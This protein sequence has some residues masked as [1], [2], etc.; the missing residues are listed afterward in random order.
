MKNLNPHRDRKE[1]LINSITYRTQ[2]MIKEIVSQK[3]L[4]NSAKEYNTALFKRLQILNTV[5]SIQISNK[6]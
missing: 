5:N 1:K 4:F 6:I 3:N 2:G